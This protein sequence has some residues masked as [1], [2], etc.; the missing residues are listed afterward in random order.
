[1]EI[2]ISWTAIYSLLHPKFPMW[3]AGIMHDVLFVPN[4]KQNL[5]AV[6]DVAKK[7][8]D[9]SITNNGKQCL[10]IRDKEIVATGH[11]GNLYKINL[12]VII[13]KDCNLS[14]SASLKDNEDK[15]DTL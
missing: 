3:K 1:M 7:G 10:F 5:F 15:L 11:I 4:L 6:K 8:I 14:N 12:R 9:F 2:Q 13:Q